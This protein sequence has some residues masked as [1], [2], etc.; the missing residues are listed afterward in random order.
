MEKII[1]RYFLSPVEFIKFQL[2]QA[3]NWPY[4]NLNE[5]DITILAYI[6]LY[7][8]KSKSQIVADRILTSMSSCHNYFVK[9]KQMEYIVKTKDGYILNPKIVILS[10]DFLLISEVKVDKDNNK[11]NHPYFQK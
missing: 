11:V 9:L 3:I 6:Y 1:R 4:Q 7:S 10:E 8:S 2:T 5:T